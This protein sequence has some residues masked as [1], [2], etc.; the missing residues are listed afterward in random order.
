MLIEKNFGSATMLV[1]SIFIHLSIYICIYRERERFWAVLHAE[2]NGQLLNQINLSPVSDVPWH[3]SGIWPFLGWSFSEGHPLVMQSGFTGG[4][5]S[6]PTS[7]DLNYW[8]CKLAKNQ[9]IRGIIPW[10]KL[11]RASS[12][13]RRSAGSHFK[14]K[15]IKSSLPTAN[16]F[17]DDMAL[18]PDGTGWWNNDHWN[19]H[20]Q[21]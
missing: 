11:W 4:S 21:K 1:H 12:F 14:A 17:E 15:T 6:I 9:T 16:T 13:F 18:P 5:T 7:S 3:H 19:N 10:E 2:T 8:N 20:L